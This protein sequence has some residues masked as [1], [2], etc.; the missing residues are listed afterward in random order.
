MI[1]LIK[2]KKVDFSVDQTGKVWVNVDDQCVLRIGE[3]TDVLIDLHH[4]NQQYTMHHE[5]GMRLQPKRKRE[6]EDGA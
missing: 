1:D 6:E 2:A 3:A 5:R 4:A